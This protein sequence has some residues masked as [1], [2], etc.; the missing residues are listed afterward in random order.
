MSADVG[1]RTRSLIL[2]RIR[3][4]LGPRPSSA[5]EEYGSIAREYRQAADLDPPARVALF[6]D[7]LEHYQV[8]VYRAE[9]ATLARAVERVLAVRSKT[10]LVVPRGVP[11]EWL[12]AVIE[13]VEDD[14]LSHADLDRV[15]G[16]LT[17]C[18]HAIAVTG[19][20]VLRH[21]PAEGRRALT[22]VPDYHLCVV[23]ADQIVQTVPE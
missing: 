12:P 14:A 23:F 2:D 17:A 22:L 3:N 21:D 5:A 10:R 8:G 1:P 4:A 16:V 15:D 6:I 9:R 19:T 13:A 18:S 11:R 20:I 7:R